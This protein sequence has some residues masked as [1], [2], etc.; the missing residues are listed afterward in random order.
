MEQPNNQNTNIVDSID[1]NVCFK[2]YIISSG[3]TNKVYIG[4]TKR[5]L[6]QRFSEH[7]S[8]AKDTKY[9]YCKSRVL[10]NE[11]SDCKID[12]I[13]YTTKDLRLQRERFWVEFYSDRAVN[14]C[15]P[16]RTQKEYNK[17]WYQQHVERIKEHRAVRINCECGSTYTRGHKTH[18]HNTKKHKERSQSV[19]TQER[20]TTQ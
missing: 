6:E 8:D 15:L 19:A 18:H 14:R 7:I 20:F 12:L 5:T 4:S 9:K 17:E 16:G 3:Q 2:I 1:E 11:F 13:E 10:I